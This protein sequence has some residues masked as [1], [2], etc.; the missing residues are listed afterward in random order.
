MTTD[1]LVISVDDAQLQRWFG[2]LIRRGQ[3]MSGLMDEIGEALLDS[4]LNRFLA[5]IGPDGVAWAPVKRGGKPL[6]DTGRMRDDIAPTSGPDWVE[7]RAVAKQAKWHQEGTD[8]YE[9]RPKNG[10]ALAF[11]PQ[12]S[13]LTGKN[14][15][16]VGP[17]Y[18][19]KKVHHPGLVARPFMGISAE[20]DQRIE[21][22]AVAWLELG[23]R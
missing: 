14:K 15:G 5:G 1:T 7:L 3:D 10:K 23:S 4:T 13:R 22:L 20:D 9:I 21:R 19:V 2:E 8:P 18:V 6:L 11:G 12:A 17:A 16:R